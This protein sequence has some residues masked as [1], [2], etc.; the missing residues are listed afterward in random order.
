MSRQTDSFLPSG[1]VASPPAF[2]PGSFLPPTHIPRSIPKLN[3]PFPNNN[4]KN[5]FISPA[6]RPHIPP[7]KSGTRNT[8]P[9]SP[10]KTRSTSA[11]ETTAALV[12]DWRAYTAK[13]RSQHEGEKAHM[14][15]DRSRADEVMNDERELWA[16]E[17][18]ILKDRIAELELENAKLRST[19]THTVRFYI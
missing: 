1:A 2:S 12:E 8:R 3:F 13:L 17:R 14:M 5:N 18:K 19:P 15:A 10:P 9:I 7:S 16:Q 4:N 6:E 11:E